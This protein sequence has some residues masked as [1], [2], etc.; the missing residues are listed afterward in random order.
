VPP[1]DWHIA[2]T[3]GGLLTAALVA[4]FVADFLRLPKVTAYLLVG[5][6]LG[7]HTI[8]SLPA[9][10]FDLVPRTWMDWTTIPEP[11]LQILHPAAE[12]AMALVLFNM[13][14]SFSFRS[15]RHYF[16]RIL[17]LSAGELLLTF[18]FVAMG[19][20]LLKESWQAALLFAALALATA[21]ATTVLVFKE[22][23]A[24]GPIT[25]YANMLVALNNLACIVVFEVLLAGIL[26]IEGSRGAAFW[27]ELGRI[28]RDLLGAIGLGVAM[29][30][31]ITFACALLSRR[32][33]LVTLIAATT[34]LLGLSRHWGFPYLLTFLAMGTTV[35]NTSDR[36]KDVAVQLDELTGLFCVAFFV[37][38]GAE[39]DVRALVHAGWIGLGYIALRAAGK[40]LGIYLFATRRDGQPVQRWLGATLMCQ[41]G[42]AIALAALAAERLPGL[43]KH[44]L[45]VILG[46][47]VVFELIGPLLI[48]Q[49]VAR[50]GE[51]PVAEL[52]HHT[53]RTPAQELRALVNRFLMAIGADPWHKHHLGEFQVADLLRSRMEQIPAAATFR[54]VLDMLAKSHNNTLPVVDEDRAVVGIIRYLDL[55][56]E[57]IDPGLGGLVNAEDLALSSFPL[58]H[59]DDPLIRAWREFQVC[60]DDC[61]P[62]VTRSQP[63]RLVGILRRREVLR[64]SPKAE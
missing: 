19:L 3:I 56:G 24:Q 33:W 34:L 20:L 42:A 6:L 55:E 36:V 32:S 10:L 52:V 2:L 9:A 7:P 47:V 41:A 5:L 60:S 37:I 61:L 39:M 8:G 25:R 4:G 13:G 62:V 1:V 57:Y 29:G 35:A 12:F 59:P 11:H 40:Y 18:S 64:L 50:S 14:C 49:A 15:F 46:T 53:E 27:L 45:D 17:R 48:R 44:L 43:G 31:A 21:P 30:V 22:S 51:V 26:Y 58:L 63:H 54:Q 28:A 38:H 23:R 16:A